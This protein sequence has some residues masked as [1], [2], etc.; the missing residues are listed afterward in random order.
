MSNSSTQ[1]R[2]VAAMLCSLT[3]VCGMIVLEGL[4]LFALDIDWGYR[5]AAREVHVRDVALCD[6]GRSLVSISIF[7]ATHREGCTYQIGMHR[8]LD[9]RCLEHCQAGNYPYRVV[10]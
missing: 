7:G 8:A 6:G 4:T 9:P 1:T 3:S 5:F 10:A 2:I